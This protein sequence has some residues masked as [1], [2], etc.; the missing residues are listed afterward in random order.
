VNI[1]SLV[2][3]DWNDVL[4]ADQKQAKDHVSDHLNKPT[5]TN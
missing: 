5:N 4:M 1:P 2:G 3:E